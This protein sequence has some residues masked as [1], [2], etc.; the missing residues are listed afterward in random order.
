MEEGGSV[1]DPTQLDSSGMS[2]IDYARDGGHGFCLAVIN[3]PT[4]ARAEAAERE[5]ELLRKEMD[6]NLLEVGRR[7][8]STINQS[9]LV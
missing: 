6:E 8:G 9:S 4:Q 3:N 1:V 5:A 2:A 7:G